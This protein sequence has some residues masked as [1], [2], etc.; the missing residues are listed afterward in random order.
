MKIKC[1]GGQIIEGTQRSW[2]V[3]DSG[4]TKR[5]IFFTQFVTSWLN[6]LPR[7]DV[8]ATS[9]NV[10]TFTENGFISSF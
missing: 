7:N 10:C 3:V 1:E 2:W 9:L 6:S 5:N 4:Q 8:I